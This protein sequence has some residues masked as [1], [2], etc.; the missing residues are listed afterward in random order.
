MY[1]NATF[2]SVLCE[3]TP[4]GV[5]WKEEALSDCVHYWHGCG[6]I[7]YSKAS[8]PRKMANPTTPPD[9]GKRQNLSLICVWMLL[10]RFTNPPPCSAICNNLFSLFTVH[11]KHAED[12]VLSPAKSPVHLTPAVLLFIYLTPPS[13]PFLETMQRLSVNKLEESVLLCGSW[14]WNSRFSQMP[15]PMDPPL[16]SS[17]E[18]QILHAAKVV[19]SKGLYHQD[20]MACE[21]CTFQIGSL[22]S[23]R[24][25]CSLLVS[26]GTAHT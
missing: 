2:I 15:L 20:N 22:Q 10:L 13:G 26:I 9:S 8:D 14:K 1:F 25:W 17:A 12:V 3:H 6:H 19:N 18:L 16:Q 24:I 11:N 21:N 4:I 7:K 23:W 5:R